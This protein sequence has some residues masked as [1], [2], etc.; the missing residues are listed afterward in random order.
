MIIVTG[1]AGFIG[2]VL[3]ARLNEAGVSDI[4]IVDKLRN[5]EKWKNL[6]GKDYTDFI[7]KEQFL[8]RLLSSE[9]Q[10]VEAIVHMGACSATTELDADYL[11]QNNFQYTRTL[12]KWCLANNSRFIYASSA[13]TYGDGKFGYSDDHEGLF[14]FK[15]LNMYGYSKQLMDEW[16]LRN[17]LEDQVVG[18]K[19]F[20]VFGPNEFH[21][22]D[23]RSVVAKAFQQI[24]ATGKAKLFNSYN[25][26]FGD[27]EQKRDF[28]YVKDVVEVIYKLIY[29]RSV[30]GIFNIGTGQARTFKDLV[31]AVFKA[32]EIEP[33]IEIVDMPV[34]LR[35]KYQYF[36]QAEMNKLANTPCHVEMRSLEDAVADYVN[37][38]LKKEWIHY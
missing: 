6:V 29:D 28:V 26:D 13:A 36:T 3:V 34:H 21:K 18:L 1:G 35:G 15:P 37:S 25:P 17:K 22:N 33:D 4:I 8:V 27:G 38:H 31:L 20:N 14:K 23:M 10:N 5:G 11:M 32:M 2:S 24:S 16:V 19:F 9:F 30:N 7:D 12:A